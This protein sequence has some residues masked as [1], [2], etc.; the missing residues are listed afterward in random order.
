MDISYGL[1]V[2]AEFALVDTQ[3]IGNRTSKRNRQRVRSRR[4]RQRV[5]VRAQQRQLEHVGR[6]LTPETNS[7]LDLEWT[8]AAATVP[9]I[10]AAA[11]SAQ[12]L[13]GALENCGR[14]VRIFFVAHRGC[15]A[16]L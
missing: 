9:V 1:C 12:A 2:A 3:P 8:V 11:A 5:P 6:V 7:L 15:A 14:L 13:V 10:A 16:A 4:V